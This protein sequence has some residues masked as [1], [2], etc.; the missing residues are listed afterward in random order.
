MPIFAVTIM[1]VVK[2][3]TRAEIEAP[4]ADILSDRANDDFDG[5]R[6]LAWIEIGSDGCGAP[7]ARRSSLSLR[8]KVRVRRVHGFSAKTWSGF[9]VNKP[10]RRIMRTNRHDRK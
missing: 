3:W 7:T 4:D 9:S 1:T 2:R 5:A 10:R 6:T 8:R